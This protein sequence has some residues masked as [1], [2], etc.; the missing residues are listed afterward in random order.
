M[1]S[2]RIGYTQ[3]SSL[4]TMKELTATVIGELDA[5]EIERLMAFLEQEGAPLKPTVWKTPWL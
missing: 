2:Q 1:T 4:E 5:S 3:A